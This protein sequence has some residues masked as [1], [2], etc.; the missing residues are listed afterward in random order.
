MRILYIIQYFATL[1]SS[2]STRS[3]EL[4]RTFREKG[5]DVD[6]LTSPVLLDSKSKRNV[7]E[8][9]LEIEGINLR[10]AKL[11]YSQ[12]MS[13]PRRSISFFWF[14]IQSIV[15]G[16]GLPKPDV[17]YA[18]STPLT[19][20]VPGII[21]SWWHGRP[22]VFEIRDLWP[23][24]VAGLGLIR[25][26]ALIWGLM[27][28]ARLGYKRSR[29]VVA[30]S[31]GMRG[32]VIA[33]GVD[34]DKVKV[35]SNCSDNHV[36]NPDFDGA[37]FRKRNDLGDA[38]IVMYAGAMGT[39][40]GL[41]YLID[42]AKITWDADK[43]V[44]FVLIGDGPAKEKL[45]ESTRDFKLENVT[46]IDPLPKSAMPEA[47]A[48]ADLCASTVINNKTME[49]NSANKFFDYLAAG[50]PVILNYG[51]WQREI[52]ENNE[53]GVSACA[54]DPDDF[55]RLVRELKNDPARR[56]RMSQNA[57]KLA[58][59][60]YDRKLLMERLF[61]M[62]SDVAKGVPIKQKTCMEKK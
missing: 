56:K 34:P 20:I 41:D 6:V 59:R 28:L 36:F 16:F 17:I 49:I 40:H 39:I 26:R 37:S 51:G 47:L 11:K 27:R 10:L 44:R 31:P 13:L 22:L 21:L 48:A 43:A 8:G 23:E 57:R 50:R 24:Q 7:K 38:F 30:L 25:N 1:E 29:L 42:A 9:T 60:E 5:W 53:A 19:V 2:V 46:F 18:S 14:L 61:S 58:E 52:L 54:G 4:A 35:I 15:L 33:H 45:K 3:F 55:A 32:G 62:V 12:K